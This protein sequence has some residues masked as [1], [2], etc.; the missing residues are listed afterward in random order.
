MCDKLQIM[1]FY[2]IDIGTW[3]PRHGVTRTPCQTRFHGQ[4]VK[5]W[6]TMSKP[7]GHLVNSSL[8][9]LSKLRGHIVKLIVTPRQNNC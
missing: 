9:R 7:R 4:V 6:D 1:F 2:S 5:V 3:G 8:D